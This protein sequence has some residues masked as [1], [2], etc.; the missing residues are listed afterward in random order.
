MNTGITKKYLFYVT[1]MNGFLLRNQTNF[2]KLYYAF[3][4]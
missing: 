1:K 3:K 4:I 2:I